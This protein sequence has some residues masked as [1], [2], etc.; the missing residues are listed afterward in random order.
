M[1]L[2]YFN[3]TPV[4]TNCYWCVLRMEM[5]GD[6]ATTAGWNNIKSLGT[7]HGVYEPRAFLPCANRFNNDGF[8]HDRSDSLLEVISKPTYALHHAGEMKK[9][10]EQMCIVLMPNEKSSLVSEPTD[11]SFGFPLLLVSSLRSTILARRFLAPFTMRRD[12]FDATPGGRLEASRHRQPC[13]K[14][15]V[16]DVS[17]QPGYRPTSQSY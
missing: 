12:L 11:C 2:K 3:S 7:N 1:V 10:F 8:R 13:R 15:V 14:E 6:L 4:D 17:R 16:W 9:T 5:G